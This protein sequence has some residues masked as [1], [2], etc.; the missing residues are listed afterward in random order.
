[1]I[2]KCFDWTVRVSK[3]SELTITVLNVF[4]YYYVYLIFLSQNENGFKVFYDAT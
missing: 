2:G 1:M 4:R 3:F